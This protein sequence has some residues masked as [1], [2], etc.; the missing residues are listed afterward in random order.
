MSLAKQITT[1]FIQMA[2]DSNRVEL[3]LEQM[4]ENLIKDSLGVLKT[5][6][7]DPALLPFDATALLRGEIDDPQSLLTPE[8]ICSVP[9]LTNS[10]KAKVN[11]ALNDSRPSLEKIIENNNNLKQ[12]LIAI[13]AP[14]TAIKV[15]G[16]TTET[17]INALLNV[18][19]IIKA[20]PIPTA[21]GAPAVAL[22]VKVLTILSSV[23]ITQE[24]KVLIAKGTI[25]IILPMIKLIS[26]ILNE[27]ITGL[28]NFE[29][30]IQSTLVFRAFL[31]SLADLGDQ[32]PAVRQVDIN[33]VT[34]DVNDTLQNALNSSGDNSLLEINQQSEADLIAS[35][36]LNY[37]GFLLE[38]VNNP[39]NVTFYPDK[40]PESPTY[41]TMLRGADFP[42]PS[43]KI[44][45]TRDF[46]D[47]TGTKNTIFT[48]TKFNTP[49]GDVTLFNDPGGKGRYSFSSSVSVLISEMKFKIDNYLLGV[50]E[51]ALP[52]I[53]EAGTG[54]GSIRGGSN[55]N[56]NPQV[57]T[58]PSSSP[59]EIDPKTG[60]TY[61]GDDPPSPTGSNT[62]PLPPAFFF[63]DTN[64]TGNA[65]ASTTLNPLSSG[66]FTVV[67]PIKIKMTTFGGSNAYSDST[68]FLR[69][70]KQGG[71][72]QVSY[73]MEQ[74]FAD[75]MEMVDTV[76]NPITGEP[77]DFLPINPFFANGTAV[78]ELGIFQYELEL[79][80][81]NGDG[82]GLDNFTTFEIE[83]Q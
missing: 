40:D 21:F 19:M 82:Q 28:I 31:K 13:R 32:C 64:I 41:K 54:G 4:R 53:T 8:N 18:I 73:M 38:L 83:A 27:V 39:D 77:I 33:K 12:A 56:T 60:L 46:T 1:Q 16:E 24:R 62:P 66:S 20:I 74:Q 68:A 69:I 80:D 70:Y 3:S 78:S 23:L 81:F 57:F 5:S 17:F 26:S 11:K 59:P 52:A 10:Q 36:P 43:R 72:G 34:A 47:D 55:T 76:N 49:L 25:S 7:I 79:T 29:N 37:K 65:V 63:P 42:F 67:R 15:T 45:A 71:S 61:G 48:R 51:L 58:P 50:N 2:K 6:T 75:N 35:F 30:T 14:I 22:P 9:P 44:R